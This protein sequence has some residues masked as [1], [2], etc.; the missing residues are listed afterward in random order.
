M[1]LRDYANGRENVVLFWASVGTPGGDYAPLGNPDWD[2]AERRGLLDMDGLVDVEGG[3]RWD[4]YGDP[5]DDRQNSLTRLHAYVD[6]PRWAAM[7]EAV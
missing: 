7:A 2:F 4:G 3:W 6:A 5:R 1:T